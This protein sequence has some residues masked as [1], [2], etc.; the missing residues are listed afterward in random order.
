MNTLTS[1]A[2]MILGFMT[3]ITLIFGLVAWVVMEKS[4]TSILY[5]RKTVYVR[6]MGQEV[7]VSDIRA[8]MRRRQVNQKLKALSERQKF[9][10]SRLGSV[11][12]KITQAGLE[13]P[14]TRWWLIC[15]GLGL[16]TS[17]AWN[18]YG[19]QTLLTPA[20]FILFTFVLPRF[21]LSRKIQKRQMLF[22]K[23]FA[24]AVDIM[25]RGLKAGMPL[26]ESVRTVST[27]IPAP[28]GPEFRI[29]I[30]QVNAGLSLPA[31][32]ERAYERLPT[33]E[34]KFFATIIAVQEQ[35]GGNLSEILS[36]ISDVLRGRA[37]L[38]EKAKALS[39]E[40]RMSAIIVGALPFLVAAV[41][42]FANRE[43]ISLLWTNR[44]GNY[45][46][47]GAVCM[48]STGMFIMNKM[49]ELDA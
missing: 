36:K 13:I 33:Q 37:M 30:D 24:N 32:L 42:F 22:T 15:I 35:N 49:G 26:Q 1:N 28:V 10:R 45:F 18:R 4:R 34:L 16:T 7:D 6:G 44:V 38:K 9:S 47:A 11:K 41:L 23:H 3:G 21:W 17:L 40:A 43:Y 5:E 39:G 46:L 31:A 48:M 12:A 14:I 29:V 8:D 2:Q 25:V 20:V 19:S 27:E